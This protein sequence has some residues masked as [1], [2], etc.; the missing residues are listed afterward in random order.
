LGDWAK[1]IKA[2]KQQGCDVFVYFDT[3]RRAQR[4]PTRSSYVECW[5]NDILVAAEKV[6]TSKSAP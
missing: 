3:T 5:G 2:W 1:R 4:P 6:W